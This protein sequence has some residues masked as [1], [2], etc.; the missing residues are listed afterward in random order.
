MYSVRNGRLKFNQ[1]DVFTV[2]HFIS[3]LFARAYTSEYVK[4]LM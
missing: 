3:S 4:A 1:D 2:S